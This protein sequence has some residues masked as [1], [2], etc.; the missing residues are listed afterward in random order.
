MS[1]AQVPVQMGGA[2]VLGAAGAR[3][4]VQGVSRAVT[5]LPATGEAIVE[6]TRHLLFGGAGLITV[7]SAM[8][9]RGRK[10]R[11]QSGKK[12]D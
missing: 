6:G 7:G 10:L 11:V 5:T 8:L 3:A 2:A 12:F 9:H 1:V 4:A